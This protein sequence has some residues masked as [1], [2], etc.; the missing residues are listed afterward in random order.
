M[1]KLECLQVTGSFKARGANN[2]LLSLDAAALGRGVITASGG[3][4]GIAVAY[5]GHASGANTVIYLSENVP[6]AKADRLRAWGAEVVVEGALW[7]DA[8]EAAMA[9]AERDGVSY[10]HPLADPA[11]SAAQRTVARAMLQQSPRSDLRALVCRGRGPASGPWC[12]RRSGAPISGGRPASETANPWFCAVMV[13][14]PGSRSRTG[15][16]A[17]RWPNF[18]L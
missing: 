18:S 7:D 15:W 11:V 13:T 14:R 1:L 9:R 16:F 2:A 5:A 8:N 10:I 17:P 3:N 4:H 6:A 12:R